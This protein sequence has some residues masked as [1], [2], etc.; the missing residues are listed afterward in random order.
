VRAFEASSKNSDFDVLRERTL[1]TNLLI[2]FD[3]TSK[4]SHLRLDN[5]R[6]LSLDLS[7]SYK[8]VSNALELLNNSTNF[9]VKS[10]DQLLANIT[11]T[12]SMSSC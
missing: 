3:K 7:H 4:S 1:N 2:N 12:M 6:Q 8:Y 11:S 9:F 10:C 5:Q